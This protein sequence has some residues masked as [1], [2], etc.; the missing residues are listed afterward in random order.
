MLEGDDVS[1][2][3]SPAGNSTYA[4]FNLSMETESV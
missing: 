4:G 3:M 2:G 1:E